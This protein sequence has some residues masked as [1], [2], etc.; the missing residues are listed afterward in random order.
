[1]PVRVR[2]AAPKSRMGEGTEPAR[3]NSGAAAR[4]LRSNPSCEEEFLRHRCFRTAER[5]VTQA[6]WQLKPFQ[7]HQQTKTTE[8]AQT[9]ALPSNL[10]WERR[11]FSGI[12]GR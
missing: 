6:E 7:L 12:R 5:R 4:R 2:P 10:L 11:C 1:M 8:V 9:K 3:S